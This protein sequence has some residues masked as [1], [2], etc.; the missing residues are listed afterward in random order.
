MGSGAAP[1]CR[2][3]LRHLAKSTAVAADGDDVA[4][5]VQEPVE[6]GGRGDGVAEHRPERE[7]C[8]ST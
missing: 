6:D 3:S 5:V 2:S 4:V 8:G 1:F 7:W